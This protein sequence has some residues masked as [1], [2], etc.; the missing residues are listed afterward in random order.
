MTISVTHDRFKLAQVFTISRGS[1]SEINVLTVRVTRGGATGWGECVPYARY[2]ETLESVTTEIEA[3]SGS[4][5]REALY[6][7]LPAGAARNAV[8]CALWDL[9][10]KQAGLSLIHI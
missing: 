7:L 5:T 8:D 2:D 4:V 6:D 3:L 10:A 1:R 9:Q